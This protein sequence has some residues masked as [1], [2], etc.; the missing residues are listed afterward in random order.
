MKRRL[1]RKM[2]EACET[3]L[4]TRPARGIL[5]AHPVGIPE[6]YAPERDEVVPLCRPPTLRRSSPSLPVSLRQLVARPGSSVRVLV[7][8][9]GVGTLGSPN[10]QPRRDLALAHARTHQRNPLLAPL[11]SLSLSLLSTPSLSVS[12]AVHAASVHYRS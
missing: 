4:P 6:G 12:L 9:E 11:S 2:E 1:E 10:S 8:Y 3:G 7:Q 5:R